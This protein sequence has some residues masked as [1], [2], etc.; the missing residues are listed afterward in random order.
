MGPPRPSPWVIRQLDRL[1]VPR[2]GYD[3]VMTSGDL[4]REVVAGR[5]GAVFHIGPERDITGYLAQ[6]L[7]ERW[8]LQIYGDHGFASGSPDWRAFLAQLQAR[9]AVL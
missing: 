8:K 7:S 4:T 2:D 3:E 9:G 6:Q 5:S 1:G